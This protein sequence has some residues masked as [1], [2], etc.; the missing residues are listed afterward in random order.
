MDRSRKQIKFLQRNQILYI[1]K[2]V[3]G[4]GGLLSKHN[5]NVQNVSSF[6]YLLSIVERPIRRSKRSIFYVA[7]QYSYYIICDHIFFDG[8]KRTG[9]D[10]S[11]L[12]LQQNGYVIIRYPRR[13]SREKNTRLT[14]KIE[15]KKMNL[16]QIASWFKRNTKKL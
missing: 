16:R 4:F 10:S 3:L 1:N 7:A 8:N 9:L 12:F 15:N 2:T 14:L 6:D 5:E 11:L 13:Y